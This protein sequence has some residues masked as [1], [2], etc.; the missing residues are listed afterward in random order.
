V[1]SKVFLFILKGQELRRVSCLPIHVC[2]RG[3]L[4]LLCWLVEGQGPDD[5]CYMGR[6]GLQ[7]EGNR[8]GASVH[9]DAT[10]AA[11]VFSKVG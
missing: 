2:L 5:Y 8:V 4:F 10:S 11:V 6:W 7:L 3:V 1:V 9:G